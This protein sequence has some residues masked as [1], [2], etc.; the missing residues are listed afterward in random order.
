MF[1]SFF[2][3]LRN[4]SSGATEMIYDRLDTAE[5]RL[6]QTVVMYEGRP[7][8]VTQVRQGAKGRIWLYVYDIPYDRYMDEETSKKKRKLV[9]L[10]DPALN[11]SKFRLGYMADGGTAH[12][13]TRTPARQ[14][15]QGLCS[16]T[17]TIQGVDGSLP[18]GFG[19]LYNTEGF[20]KMLLGKYDGLREAT[21]KIVKEGAKAVPI[22]RTFLLKRN[23]QARDFPITLAYRG[24]DIAWSDPSNPTKFTLSR[25][26]RH[27]KEQAG[28]FNLAL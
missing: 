10:D 19:N 21:D 27:L 23:A 1:A 6:H 13:I 4:E 12:Y 8:Y 3:L 25:E 16:G 24:T 7:V 2:R 28:E 20:A 18:R 17:I 15:R 22:A 5:M 14:N 26:F 11:V 9:Y